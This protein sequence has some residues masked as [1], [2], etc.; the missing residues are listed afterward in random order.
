M[1]DNNSDS[2]ST[3][4]LFRYSLDKLKGFRYNDIEYIYKR[5]IQGDIIQIINGAGDVVA[6]YIYDAWGNHKVLNPDGTENT[7]PTFIGNINPFRYRGYYFDSETSLYYL[8]SRYY[9]SEVGRFISPDSIDYLDPESIN[10]LNLYCYCINNP[11][12]YYDPSGH[13]A[14]LAALLV[15][16]IVGGVIGGV[17]GGLTAAANDQNVLAG[18]LIGIGAGA[19]MG[20]GAGVASLYLAPV[21]VGQAAVVGGV[22][23]SAGAALAIG[24]GIAFGSGFIGGMA[25]DALTQVVNDGGVNDWGSVLVSGFQWGLINT[26]SAF[27]CSLG[28]PVSKLNNVLLSVIFGS[29]TSAVGMTIDILRNRKNQKQKVVASNQLYAYGF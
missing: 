6:K 24:S 21:I 9:D 2:Q 15:G 29:V 26:A 20:A 16:A 3:T 18:V 13:S 8:N 1:I 5:N 27:L 25:A 12:S 23:Y 4:L 7:N 19:L 10:G 28:G 22:T 14:I 11:I 17:Y